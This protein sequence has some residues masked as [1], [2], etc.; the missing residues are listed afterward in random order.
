ML[1]ICWHLQY[2]VFALFIGSRERVCVLPAAPVDRSDLWLQAAGTWSRQSPQCFLLSDL[3]RR[4]QPQL[5]QRPH[6][7]RGKADTWY[8]ICISPTHFNAHRLYVLHS[9]FNSFGRWCWLRGKILH[10]IMYTWAWAL[11]NGDL[12]SPYYKS[13]CLFSVCVYPWYF[14]CH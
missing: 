10:D 13:I 9:W 7:Q 6:A 4:S 12:I 11:S 1:C 3:R 8:S 2:P 14:W 5:H